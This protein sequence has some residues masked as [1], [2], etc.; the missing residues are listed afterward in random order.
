MPEVRYLQITAEVFSKMKK[1]VFA[2]ENANFQDK[3]KKAHGHGS[4][5][6]I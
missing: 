6:T 5:S 3:V 1:K 2:P 4:F